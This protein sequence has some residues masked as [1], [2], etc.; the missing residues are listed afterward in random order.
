MVISFTFISSMILVKQAVFPVPGAPEMYKLPGFPFGRWLCRND[1]M[2]AISFSRHSKLSGCEECSALLT[3]E[4]WR[5]LKIRV[6]YHILLWYQFYFNNVILVN[7]RFLVESIGEGEE[8]KTIIVLSQNE[9]HREW[10]ILPFLFANT[11]FE[12]D[13]KGWS[14]KHI[15]AILTPSSMQI[16]YEFNFLFSLGTG[17]PGMHPRHFYMYMG[18]KSLLKSSHPTKYL[19]NF[20]TPKEIPE[21]KISNP[22]KSFDHPCHLKSGLSS[23]ESIPL[24]TILTS[25]GQHL[26]CS[27]AVG[28]GGS[29][30]SSLSLV[31]FLLWGFGNFLSFTRWLWQPK[32]VNYCTG[33]LISLDHYM[34]LGNCPSL[35]QH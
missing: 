29:C 7:A 3:L 14:H 4:Y 20:P 16:P 34:L 15:L 25:K 17:A 28:T 13:K 5:P 32:R 26:F 23:W 24:L 2:S 9:M 1:L 21:S 18:G 12:L 30:I 6:S 8:N 19:A 27:W 33:R 11:A 22:Q 35:S 10:L 31:V